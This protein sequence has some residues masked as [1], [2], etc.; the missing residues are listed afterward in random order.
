MVNT[1]TWIFKK[2]KR[3]KEKKGRVGMDIM[4][5]LKSLMVG[6]GTEIQKSGPITSGIPKLNIQ[7]CC[8]RARKYAAMEYHI[9]K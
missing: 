3:N 6:A 5:L 7:R 8:V 2:R 4:A 1:N 9:S